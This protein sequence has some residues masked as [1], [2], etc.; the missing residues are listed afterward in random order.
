MSESSSSPAP[1]SIRELRIPDD[2]VIINFTSVDPTHVLDNP[3]HSN[4]MNSDYATC[5][6]TMYCDCTVN[7]KTADKVQRI[8]CLYRDLAL[9]NMNITIDN[10]KQQ[11]QNGEIRNP[12]IY[13]ILDKFFID[14]PDIV[15]MNASWLSEQ[16]LL[17][18]MKKQ[19]IHI[20][21]KSSLLDLNSSMNESSDP[22][23]CK[24]H[25]VDNEK[26]IAAVIDDPEI[27]CDDNREQSNDDDETSAAK[28][29]KKKKNK[30][31]KNLNK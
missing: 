2:S 5:A 19:Q 18:L 12:K 29:Q 30:R 7:P 8:L 6:N 16:A 25:S 26:C 15:G 24:V 17:S 22:L 3:I 23:E 10:I 31:N 9:M 21:I 13:D 4:C 28:P 1:S 27:A 14:V 20:D 11:M